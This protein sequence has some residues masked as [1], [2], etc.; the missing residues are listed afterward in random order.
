M[1]KMDNITVAIIILVLVTLDVSY[2]AFIIHSKSC[3]VERSFVSLQRQRR[4]AG[5]MSMK[6]EFEGASGNIQVDVRKL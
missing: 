6:P 2:A 4:T 1:N 3:V 5:I